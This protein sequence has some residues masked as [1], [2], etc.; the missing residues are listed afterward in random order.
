M[1]EAL[2]GNKVAEKCL[3][4]IVNYG[5]GHI[6]GISKTFGISPSQVERQL[7][8]LEAGGILINKV[9]G[10]T[11]MFS[12]NPRLGIRKE[13]VLLLERILMLLPSSEVEKYYRERRRP[14]RTGKD[15]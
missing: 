11:K 5:E 4:Y 14:R 10:N 8:R 3:L 15:L 1:Y 12:I 9:I 13:L 7:K 2:F 6:N